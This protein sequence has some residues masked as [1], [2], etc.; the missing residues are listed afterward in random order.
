MRLISV[1]KRIAASG[2]FILGLILLVYF[3]YLLAPVSNAENNAMRAFVVEKGEGFR[4]IVSRLHDGGFIRSKFGFFVLAFTGAKADDLKPG[5]YDLAPSLSSFEILGMLARGT[6]HEVSV[7][8]PEGA[9]L[10]EIDELLTEREIITRGSLVALRT[11]N[12]LEGKLF[13]DT[14]RFMT[15]S[16]PEDI[17]AVMLKNFEEKGAPILAR[18]PAR[19]RENLILASLLEAEVPDFEE[20]RVV[21]GILRKR[22]SVGMALQVDAAICY[23]KENAHPSGTAKCY[24]LTPL[25]FKEDSP[26]NT[27]LHRGLPPGPIGN[28]GISALLAAVS[29]EPSE[30]WFYLSDPATKKTIFAKTLDEHTK[31]RVKYLRRE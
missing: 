15:H 13:P 8:I 3:F 31:N 24:P 23:M 17:A 14:Y 27:Y 10:N 12:E 20:R 6:S 22:L 19:A 21:A 26:Y 25:D 4:E 18:D 1:H 9:A 29:P 30:Y 28:P 16:A 11:R 2:L 5:A 7:R